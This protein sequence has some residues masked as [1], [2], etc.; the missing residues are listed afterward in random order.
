MVKNRFTYDLVIHAKL[1]T[2]ESK[3]KLEQVTPADYKFSKVYKKVAL[4]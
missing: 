3:S 1:K 4:I 2:Q